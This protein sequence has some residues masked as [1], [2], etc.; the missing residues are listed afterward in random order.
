M[1]NKKS[2]KVDLL[3]S[4]L[5]KKQLADFIRKEC[6]NDRQFKDRFLAL[7]AGTLFK[8]TA[9]TYTARVDKLI[10]KYSDRYGFIEYH[11]ASEFNCAVMRIL[12]EAHDAIAN[13]QWDVAIAVLT[14]VA[15]ASDDI[16]NNGDDS[17]GELGAIVDECFKLWHKLCDDENLPDNIKSEIFELALDRFNKQDLK[18]WDWWWDWIEIAIDLALNPVQQNSVFNALDA[19]PHKQDDKWDYDAKTALNYKLKLMSKFDSLDNQLKFMYD[20]VGN[21]DFRKKLLQIAWDESNFDEVLRLAKEGINHDSEYAGLLSDWHKWEYKVYCQLGDKDNILLLARH[22]FF[23]GNR[24]GEV[25]Y[26]MDKMYSRMKDLIPSDKWNDYVETLISESKSKNDTTRLLYI[27]MQEKMWDRYME[28]LRANPSAY[29]IDA[30]PIEVKKLYKGEIVN[31]YTVAVR[32]F[33]QRASSR[34][35][36][37][38]GV[39]LLRNLIKYGG[40]SEADKIAYEQKTRTPRRPALID[41]LSKL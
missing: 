30:A 19:I 33:F 39:G 27:Y 17:D 26:S 13:H 40:K 21:S 6:V 1:A 9:Q 22:F 31:L 12:D 37:R 18:G 34:D 14:G 2:D 23:S 8:P 28:Y 38:E 20:N 10:D 41:E 36:Y 7:G 32:R 5:D 24:W 16:I 35:T 29:N 11:L 3:L 4:K 15:A 25:E